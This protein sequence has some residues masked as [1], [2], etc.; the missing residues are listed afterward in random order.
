M[1]RFID[2]TGK[3]FGR[4]TVIERAESDRN[5]LTQWRCRCS[6]GSVIVTRSQ[7]LRRGASKSCGCR[8]RE[9]T[10]DR[11][12]RHGMAGTRPYRIWK[13]MKTRCFN[14]RSKSYSNYGGRGITVCEKWANSFEAFWEDM[15]PTYK[16][17]LELDRID[18]NGN[19]EPGNCRWV[20]KKTQNRNTR[21]NRVVDSPLGA[22]PLSELAELTGINYG[23]LKSRANR[24]L[25]FEKLI[26]PVQGR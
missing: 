19:Y 23:T 20:D 16:D 9:V 18:P 10:A 25:P 11:N 1:G 24:G 17:G 7:D 3:T 21:A 22:M 12:L 4:L 6:C 8:T 2:L 26:A 15:G 5:G 13:N 14:P